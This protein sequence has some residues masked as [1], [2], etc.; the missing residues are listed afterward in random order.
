MANGRVAQGLE[1][2]RQA[3]YPC[4]EAARRQ[5]TIPE[6]RR[7]RGPLRRAR[8]ADRETGE[9]RAARGPTRGAA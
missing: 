3:H 2:Q 1:S 5:D 8:A 6:P 9:A 7:Q 4:P